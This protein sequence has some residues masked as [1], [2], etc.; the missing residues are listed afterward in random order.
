MGRDAPWRMSGLKAGGPG[1]WPLPKTSQRHS[2]HLG[3]GREGWSHRRVGSRA[4]PGLF[5]PQPEFWQ[6]PEAG[7]TVCTHPAWTLAGDEVCPLPTHPPL[8]S[9]PQHLEGKL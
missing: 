1:D 2:C 7:R 6:L 8:G 9:Q 5:L 3:W 4:P